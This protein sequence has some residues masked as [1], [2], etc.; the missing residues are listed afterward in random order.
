MIEVR[1]LQPGEVAL[2]RSMRLRMLV[3]SPTAFG[4]SLEQAELRP[5]TYWTDT[6]VRATTSPLQVIFMAWDD[7]RVCGTVS[8]SIM[9]PPV[10][11]DDQV[12]ILSR[13][14]TGKSPGNNEMV[15]LGTALTE[16]AQKLA[17]LQ[18]SDHRRLF[19]FLIQMGLNFADAAR[20]VPPPPPPGWHGGPLPFG[21]PPRV[22][23]ITA[24]VRGMW[25]DPEYRRKGVGRMLL[26]TLIDWAREQHAEHMELGVTEGNEPAIALYKRVGFK[27]NGQRMPSMSNPNLRFCFMECDIPSGAT[28]LRQH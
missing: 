12:A 14:V 1:R 22:T 8:G 11:T 17:T 9:L 16:L 27:D 18:E 3:D 13:A 26:D 28:T 4:E 5:D 25:V 24:H 23:C 6:V 2:Y 15:A 21:G 20:I 19:R 7:S 10:L